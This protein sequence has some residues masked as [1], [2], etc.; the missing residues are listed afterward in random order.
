MWYAQ[1]RLTH[2]HTHLLQ[3]LGQVL[4]ELLFPLAELLDVPLQVLH[5]GRHLRHLGFRAGHFVHQL[6]VL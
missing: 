2:T 5:G 1:T 6:V 3:G 4:V